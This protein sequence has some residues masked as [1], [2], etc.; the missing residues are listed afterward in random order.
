MPQQHASSILHHGGCKRFHCQAQS[1][2]PKGVVCR[3]AQDNG[4]YAK[5]FWL[6]AECCKS[7]EDVSS[8]KVSQQLNSTINHLYEET[9]QR[10]EGALQSVCNDFHANQYIKVGPCVFAGPL[11]VLQCMAQLVA[12]H[13]QCTA[14]SRGSCHVHDW[15]ACT[16]CPVMQ[17]HSKALLHRTGA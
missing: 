13:S 8:L 9:I 5:A 11:N 15:D 17:K 6:C 7:M 3:D 16:P 10:L 1:S 2:D 14:K 4:E 12:L